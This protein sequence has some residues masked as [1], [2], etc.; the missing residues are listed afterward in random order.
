[1]IALVI[2]AIRT[3]TLGT[4]FVQPARYLV[5]VQTLVFAIY[6]S[7]PLSSHHLIMWGSSQQ[8]LEFPGPQKILRTLG[9]LLLSSTA[10]ERTPGTLRS[11]PRSDVSCQAKYNGQDT[12]CFNYP[13]GQML[14]TQFWDTDPA[15][16]PDDSWTIHGLW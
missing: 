11:C 10:E 15:V 12:C 14:Q 3:P 16:G 2:W 5:Q 6:L 7:L 4:L 1:M 9:S 8:A 13:G